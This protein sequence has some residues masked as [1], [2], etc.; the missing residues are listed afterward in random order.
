MKPK[1]NMYNTCPVKQI[2]TVHKLSN[3]TKFQS[4]KTQ[5]KYDQNIEFLCCE[6]MKL[7]FQNLMFSIQENMYKTLSQ[8]RVFIVQNPDQIKC[9]FQVASFKNT[10][11]T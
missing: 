9:K 10:Q 2:E 5:L 11:K 3:Y 1:Q 4:H 6:T 7:P 8:V